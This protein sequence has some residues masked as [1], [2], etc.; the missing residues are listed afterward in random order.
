MN[1]LLLNSESVAVE[2]TAYSS[3]GVSHEI[4]VE[5]PLR[6]SCSK[7]ELELSNK[8]NNSLVAPSCLFIVTANFLEEGLLLVFFKLKY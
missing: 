5:T 4:A 8:D 1:P 3:V 2:E 7:T 6:S